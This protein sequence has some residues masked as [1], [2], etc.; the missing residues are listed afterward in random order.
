MSNTRYL[1]FTAIIAVASSACSARLSEPA[2]PV[3]GNVQCQGATLRSAADAMAYA[4]CDS[5]VGDLRIKQSSLS[6]LDSLSRLRSVS[7]TLEISA[8]VQLE[9]VKGL[10]RLSSVGA[11]EVRDN[12]ELDSLSGLERLQSAASVVISGNPELETLQ[13]LQQLE[14]VQSLSLERNG[15]YETIG[16]E[17]LSEVGSLVIRDNPRLISLRGFKGLRRAT[18][19]DIQRNPRLAAYYGLLP[20]L[21]RVEGSLVL[22]HNLG[23]SKKDVRQVVERVEERTQMALGSSPPALR[24]ASLR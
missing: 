20:E 19:I 13:G 1:F 16:L 18:S 3:G 2:A 21:E 17:R 6:N 9:D 7:G 22:R 23:L 10:S 11:L 14:H 15:I 5:V 4:V 24:E 8:N 12:R